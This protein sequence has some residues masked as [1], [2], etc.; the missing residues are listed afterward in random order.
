M[1][2]VADAHPAT[3]LSKRGDSLDRR[4]AQMRRLLAAMKPCAAADG[5]RM[6]RERFPDVPLSERVQV[7]SG[8]HS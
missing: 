5:L 3:T 6:L 8:R 1:K 4:I 2:A 7:F